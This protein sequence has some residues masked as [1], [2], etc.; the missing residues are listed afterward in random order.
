[1]KE[2]ESLEVTES[3]RKYISGS[4]IPNSDDTKGENNKEEKKEPAVDITELP[5][6]LE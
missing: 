4:D 1:M 3:P 5:R 2:K 6:K